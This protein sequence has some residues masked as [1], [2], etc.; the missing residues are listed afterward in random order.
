MEAIEAPDPAPAA[1]SRAGNST[2]LVTALPAGTWVELAADPAL[3]QE[4]GLVA[5]PPCGAPMTLDWEEA[6]EAVVGLP[7]CST[8]PPAPGSTPTPEAPPAQHP[9]GTH[10]AQANT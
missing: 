2:G 4:P 10:V 3:N 5:V 9:N 7:S 1:P 8:S 6:R